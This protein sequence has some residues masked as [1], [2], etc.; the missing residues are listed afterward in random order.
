VVIGSILKVPPADAAPKATSNQSQ[1]QAS[2]FLAQ[3][4]NAV[5]TDPPQFVKDEFDPFLGRTAVSDR[6]GTQRRRRQVADQRRQMQVDGKM[7]TH[8]GRKLRAGDIVHSDEHR[9]Q[10]QAS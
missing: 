5:G 8:R 10:A 3:A 6:P 4:K 9:V 2:T 7:D 1:Q